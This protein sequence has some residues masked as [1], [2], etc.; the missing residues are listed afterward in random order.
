MCN[1][2][3]SPSSSWNLLFQS[4]NFRTIYILF[5]STHLE[6]KNKFRICEFA[7]IWIFLNLRQ[8]HFSVTSSLKH[9]NTYTKLTFLMKAPT[10]TGYLQQ[11]VQSNLVIRNFLITLKFFLNVK[12]YLPLWSK[13]AFGHGKWFLNTNLFLIKT[14]LITKFDCITCCK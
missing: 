13:L 6:L 8:L 11:V 4:S 9:Y 12:S 2:F 14:F 1:F 3:Y 7:L 10:Y 5:G